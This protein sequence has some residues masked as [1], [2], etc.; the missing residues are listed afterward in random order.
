MGVV[1]RFKSLIGLA[2]TSVVVPSGGNITV[3]N[4]RATDGDGG[5]GRAVPAASALGLSAV[6]A[7]V[8]LLAGT[9]ASLPFQVQKRGA[10]GVEVL[11]GHPLHRL[12]HESPNYDQTALDFWEF[13]AASL[14]LWGNAYAVVTR[15]A[16]RIVAIHPV[17]PELM[18][19]RR[20]T[21]GELE[22][23]WVD[24]G[25]QRVVTDREI[26]HVRGFGGDPLGGLSTL[27]HARGVFG[28]ARAVD[29]TAAATFK[30]GMQP[31]GALVFPEWLSQENRMLA[32]TRM[33]EKYMGAMNTGRPLIL[34][35]GT[36]WTPLTIKPEDAQML[37]SRGFSVEEICR[38]FGVPPFMVG[39][40][41]K[42]TS[43]GS[44]IE[45][46]TL[47]FQKF[48]LRRRLKRIEQAVAK[49]LLTDADRAQGI[50]VQFNIEGLLRGDSAGRASYYQTMTQIGAMTIN[51]VRA[52]EGLPPVP[53]GDL[54]RMQSQNVP[55]SQSQEP[56]NE[57]SA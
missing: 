25:K 45:Q 53:G 24:H 17:S 7:C 27:H 28:L 13:I 21:D 8:N 47:G 22:Y 12:L 43:W 50:K 32:E 5:V 38:F 48:T 36:T 34:E 9:I 4:A 57:G 14:E 51:E 52:L 56:E 1:E 42:T 40:T 39:H 41:E 44:G 31:S 46:Q 20:R 16:G 29:R 6:W 35:G 10:S 33:T 54:P 15:D 30:N 37:E 2:G 23:R 11:K 49:Q 18:E 3:N 55:I 26:L 19:V